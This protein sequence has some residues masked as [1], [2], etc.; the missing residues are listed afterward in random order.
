MKKSIFV[1]MI[2]AAILIIF[3]LN[4]NREEVSTSDD[5]EVRSERIGEVLESAWDQFK[6]FSFSVGE[7]DS[8]IWIEMDENSSKQEILAYLE[9]NISEKDLSNYTIKISRRSLQEVKTEHAMT[10]IQGF[11]TDYI[12][13]KNYDN[14]EVHCPLNKSEAV[15]KVLIDGKSDLSS[16]ELKAE[17][18]NYLAARKAELPEKLRGILYEIRVT[19]FV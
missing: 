7:T 3:D 4:F 17:I 1:I 18:E 14:V 11:A 13:E 2:S 6:L 8:V 5:A 10:L 16:D 15:L 12:K 9:K 19:V